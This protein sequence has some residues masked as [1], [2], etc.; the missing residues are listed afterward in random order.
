MFFKLH[1][2]WQLVKVL[3]HIREVFMKKVFNSNN[4]CMILHHPNELENI[5]EKIV[6]IAFPNINID[7]KNDGI[8]LLCMLMGAMDIETLK[9]VGFRFKISKA[10]KIFINLFMAF[11]HEKKVN[12]YNKPLFGSIKSLRRHRQINY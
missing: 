9:N 12:S 4:S 8:S 10:R 3:I 5:D 1:M 2:N 11:L 7:F 6:N